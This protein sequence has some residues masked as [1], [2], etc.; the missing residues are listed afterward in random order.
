MEEE[1]SKNIYIK[2]KVTLEDKGI[3]PLASRMRSERSTTELNPRPRSEG[4]AY[5]IK[6]AYDKAWLLHLPLA[7]HLLPVRAWGRVAWISNPK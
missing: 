5:L 7:V 3:E 6:Y 4:L 2:K 1:E